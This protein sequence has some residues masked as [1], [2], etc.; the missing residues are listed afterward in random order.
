MVVLAIFHK[1]FTVCSS[2]EHQSKK[3]IISLKIIYWTLPAFQESVQNTTLSIPYSSFI[4]NIKKATTTVLQ[5]TTI[6]KQLQLFLVWNA[7]GVYGD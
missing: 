2:K 3:Q 5:L 4:G 1:E 6:R 7:K